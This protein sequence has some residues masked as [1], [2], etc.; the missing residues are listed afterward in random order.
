MKH[1]GI[2]MFGLLLFWTG[3]LSWCDNTNTLDYE[4]VLIS[5][6]C[7]IDEKRPLE[8]SLGTV[9]DKL[10]YLHKNSSPVSFSLTL[11]NCDESLANSVSI[12]L[13]APPVNVTS[14]G[15]LIFDEGSV[16]KGAVIGIANNGITHERISIGSSLPKQVVSNGTMDIPLSAYLHITPDAFTNK[17]IVPGKFSATLYYLVE[18]N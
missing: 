8:V 17:A 4:G 3:T 12:T 15:Y 7:V 5:L 6:A 1:L 18:F 9:E 2:S 14:D 10:L 13:K 11:L 16:A